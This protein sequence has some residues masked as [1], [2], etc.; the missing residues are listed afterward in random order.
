LKEDVSGEHLRQY[1]AVAPHVNLIVVGSANDNF[2]GAIRSALYIGRQ[3]VRDK[4]AGAE[5]DQLNFATG[6]A[7]DND[8]FLPWVYII[9]AKSVS[10]N[11]AAS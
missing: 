4:T 10:N 8:I 2:G 6:V 1:C 9:E 5:I 11:I 3:M 7:L